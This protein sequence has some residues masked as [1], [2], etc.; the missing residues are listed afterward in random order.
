MSW[1]LL[2]GQLIKGEIIKNEMNSI[3]INHHLGE[4][5]HSLPGSGFVLS[6]KLLA[7]FGDNMDRFDTA[8]Q[9]QCLFGTAPKNYQSGNYHKVLMRKACN[10]SARAVLYTFA[11]TTLRYSSWARSYYDQQRKKGKTHSV[12]VRALSNKWVRVIFRMWKNEENYQEEKKISP[13]A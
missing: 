2:S 5:F 7:L 13:A 9:A 1:D 12:S 4:V 6:A 3:L 11:F 8:N 10:K